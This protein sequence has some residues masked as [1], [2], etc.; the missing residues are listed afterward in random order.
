MMKKL[1][2]ILLIVLLLIVFNLPKETG[3]VEGQRVNIYWGKFY[4]DLQKYLMDFRA[5]KGKCPRPPIQG[6]CLTAD[7]VNKIMAQLWDT[8][9][10]GVLDDSYFAKTTREQR[11]NYLRTAKDQ[12]WVLQN[13]VLPFEY[14]KN[15]VI[16]SS[17]GSPIQT[18]YEPEGVLRELVNQLRP[19]YSQIAS[20]DPNWLMKGDLKI[21]NLAFF[22]LRTYD[23]G[24]A[25]LQIIAKSDIGPNALDVIYSTDRMKQKFSNFRQQTAWQSA[26]TSELTSMINNQNKVFQLIKNQQNSS[27]PYMAK[28]KMTAVNAALQKLN[29]GPGKLAK[30]TFF[31][32]DSAFGV[33]L[34]PVQ[35]GLQTADFS[36][37]W[38]QRLYFLSSRK[39]TASNV[40]N[41]LQKF[42]KALTM[43][44]KSVRIYNPN[45][46][47]DL[48]TWLLNSTFITNDK[49]I[50]KL[51]GAD[52]VA[53]C[54]DQFGS[55]NIN[56]DGY[57]FEY[58]ADSSTLISIIIHEFNHKNRD[59]AL[60]RRGFD[61]NADYIQFRNISEAL[62][63]NVTFQILKNNGYIES[64]DQFFAGYQSFVFMKYVAQAIT[65][66]KDWGNG[67][68]LLYT[69][70][71]KPLTE[72]DNMLHRPG[73]VDALDTKID[74]WSN[75]NE[76]C[77]SSKTPSD[78]KSYCA[79]A[80]QTEKDIISF[81]KG[82]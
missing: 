54:Y 8:N 52:N 59:Y 58:Q 45:I 26:E 15:Y 56:L 40:N 67:Q 44:A 32:K 16:Y 48:K 71:N 35:I 19:N 47:T 53:G 20:L 14:Q 79:S 42:G 17:T 70:N 33:T 6:A 55:K 74:T 11:I 76:K 12:S 82:P 22:V 60:S 9:G 68:M 46:D 73:F 1:S 36:N 10:D 2:K 3:A 78:R 49:N 7:K 24:G 61:S 18:Y 75:L 66:F 30:G 50:R 43:L 62:T 64:F 65:G 72:F 80:V 69:Y 25:D 4:G 28:Q 13:R 39:T 34:Y 29:V 27:S 57:F 51:C 41:D 37:F 23:T 38:I 77:N 21:R 5:A 31:L 63:D 81:I